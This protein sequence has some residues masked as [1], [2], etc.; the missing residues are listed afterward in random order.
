MITTIATDKPL[1]PVGLYRE[2]LDLETD[3]SGTIVLHHG[4]VK[5]P[6]KK[7]S[8]FAWVELRPLIPDVEGRLAS[9]ALEAKER[10]G[11]NQVLVAHRLGRLEAGG[12]V[13]VAIASGK[14]RDRCFDA[15]SWMVDTIKKEEFIELV[16]IP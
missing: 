2:F 7:V 8:D 6:G 12:T 10:F 9:L 16:E 3:A 15:C 1:D 11:L 5:R 13:L 4:R 14:T